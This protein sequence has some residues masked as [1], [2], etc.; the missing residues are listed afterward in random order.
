LDI[1]LPAA[2]VGQVLTDIG[3]EVE[4]IEEHKGP[5]NGLEGLVVGHV[6]HIEKH[7]DAD[8]LRV[9]K[10]DVGTGTLLNIVCGAPNVDAGQKVIVATIGATLHPTIGEAF[11]IKRSKIRGVESEGMLCAEDEIGTG[12]S[13]DG[14]KLLPADAPIGMPLKDYWNVKSDFIF[15]IGLTPNRAD[16]MGHIGVARDLQAALSF[17]LGREV[18][19]HLPPI[20]AFDTPSNTP[21]TVEVQDP[22]ACPRYT[23]I[24]LEHITVAKSP[25]WLQQRLQSVGIRPINNVVDVTNYILLEFAQPLHAFDADAIAGNKVIV[26]TWPEGTE[27]VTL[28]DQTRKLQAEDLMISNAQEGMCIAG[29]FGGAKSGVKDSTTR[30]FLESAHFN[31]ITIRKTANRLNL[32]TDAAQKYEKGTDPNITV[33]ALKRAVNL[34]IELAGAKVASPI[35]DVYPNPV[36]PFKVTLKY[37]NCDRLIGHPIPPLVVKQ[38]LQKLEIVI[39]KSIYGDT[40]V[41]YHTLSDNSDTEDGTEA[42]EKEETGTNIF[43][44]KGRHKSSNPEYINDENFLQQEVEE[45]LFDT[46]VDQKGIFKLTT[47]PEIGLEL[48]IPPFKVDVTREADIIEEVLR[49]YG[50]NNIPFPASLRFSLSN[51]VGVEKELV[52]NTLASQLAGGGFHEIMVNPITNSQYMQQNGLADDMV[53]LLNSLNMGLDAMRTSTLFGGLES[54]AH[55]VNRRNLDLKFFEF[56]KT[57]HKTADGN[58]TEPEHLSLFVTGQANGES[59]KGKQTPSDFFLLKSQ[60]EQILERLGESGF[61]PEY[62]ESPVLEYGLQYRAGQKV[63]VSYGKVSKKLLKQ[64]DIKQDVY[65]ADLNWTQLLRRL[66]GRKTQ[67]KEVS[68][69]PGVR[70]DLALLLDKAVSYAEIEKI[71][72]REVKRTLK[73]V[74]LFDRYEDAK[75]GD[76]KKSYAVSFEFQDEGKTLTDKDVDKLVTRLIETYKNELGADIRQ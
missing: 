22:I 32:R 70:R 69:F 37:A 72:L 56:G 20:P 13:H 50:F 39:V 15:E 57:Y 64:F 55:N 41:S 7:P 27:F 40:K 48:Q 74:N 53:T 71:A 46:Q 1:D 24:T 5:G 76:N 25:A 12:V 66:N 67:Y 45:E 73:S 17:R 60:V 26:R 34:L 9:T 28:D 33:T 75:L 18:S 8:K 19:Y 16:A 61:E 65:Y 10:V 23:G 62:A 36:Q 54:I 51:Q 52:Q 38:I 63:L 58:Y 2:E 44:Q 29:V 30:I 68:K 47:T 11:T 43:S 6:T 42:I 21:I 14:I 59:W 49:I 3:L 31:P 35:V 4:H